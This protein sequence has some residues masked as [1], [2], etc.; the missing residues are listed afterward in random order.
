M[1]PADVANTLVVNASTGHVRTTET[2]ILGRILR[3]LNLELDSEMRNEESHVSPREAAPNIPGKRRWEP[4]RVSVYE[5][6]DSTQY[7]QGVPTRD[8]VWFLGFVVIGV[9]LF[10]A[11]IPWIVHGQWVAFVITLAGNI[12]AVT[13]ASLPKWTEEKWDSPRGVGP[14]VTLTHGNGSR[15][16]ITILESRVGLDLDILARG[17]RIS[18][19]SPIK[20]LLTK[21]IVAVLAVLWVF[22]LLSAAGLKPNSWCKLNPSALISSSEFCLFFSFIRVKGSQCVE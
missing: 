18:E 22:L 7:V 14:T 10:I 6:I 11:A 13:G 9:E 4:L 19:E 15:H 8:W 2:W 21:T 12:L 5:V 20:N 16:A 3:D 1:P 17:T